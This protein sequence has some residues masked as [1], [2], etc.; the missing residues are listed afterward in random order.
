MGL[1]KW[2]SRRIQERGRGKIPQAC[3]AKA[4]QKGFRCR[5]AQTTV[6]T[7]E[8]LHKLEIPEFHHEAALVDVEETVDF[9]LADRLLKCNAGEHFER[10]AVVSPEFPFAPLCSLKYAAMALLRTSRVEKGNHSVDNP[11]LKP[12]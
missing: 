12:D 3:Q 11:K 1:S 5:K 7:G 2:C 10:V 8:L 6:G 9:R 4:L